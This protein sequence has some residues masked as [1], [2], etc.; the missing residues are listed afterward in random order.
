MGQVY[1][2]GQK[3]NV[4]RGTVYSVPG[5]VSVLRLDPATRGGGD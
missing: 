3:G 1:R 5:R 4:A 2:Q